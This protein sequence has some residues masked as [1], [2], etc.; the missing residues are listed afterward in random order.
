MTRL[1]TLSRLGLLFAA[2]ATAPAIAQTQATLVS[3][4]TP[5]QFELEGGRI[6]SGLAFDVPEGARQAR[7]SLRGSSPAH[8]IQLYVRQGTPFDL[9]APGVDLLQVQDQAHYRSTSAGSD[10][11]VVISDTS[12]VPLAAGRWF[13]AAVNLASSPSTLTLELQIW[14][15]LQTAPIELIFNDPGSTSDNCNQ[16][17]WSDGSARGPLRGNPGTTLGEQRRLAALEAARLLGDELKPRVPIRVRACWQDLGPASGTTFTLA[18]AGPRFWFVSAPYWQALAPA[19]QR[20]HTWYAAAAAA[21]QA[22][23]TACRL[24]RSLSCERFADVQINFNLNVDS[25]GSGFD[26]GFQHAVGA[27]SSFISVAMHEISHGLGFLGLINLNSS[28]GPVGSKIRLF[29]GSPLWDDIYGSFARW[30][31]QSNAGVEFLRLTDAERLQALTAGLN[32]RFSG[33]NAVELNPNAGFGPP[34]S[35]VSLHAPSVIA[36]GSTYSHVASALYGPQL[37]AANILASGPRQLGIARGILDDV[38]FSRQAKASPKFASAPSYQYFDPSR[39]GHGID[40]R[41]ISPAITGTDAEYFMGF[42]TFD[43]QGDPEWYIASG[44]LVDGVFIPKRNEFGDSLLRMR[45]EGPNQSVPDPSAGYSGQVRVNFNSAAL[46]PACHDGHP[47]RNLDRALA[48]MSFEINGELLEW[49]MQPVATPTS[50]ENDFSSIWYSLD[51]GGWGL[52]IQSFDNVPT[53]GLFSILYYADAQGLPRWAI[54]QE[55]NFQS[56]ATYPLRQVRGYCRTCPAPAELTFDEVGSI[57]FGLVR[58]GAGS[59]GNTVSFDVTYPG[60]QGG[61]FLRENVD[62]FPNSDPPPPPGG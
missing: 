53:D 25:G 43:A 26:Y 8:N 3:P 11:F 34:A 23:T 18:N 32:L 44:P 49:C 45:Y 40:F 14:N 46:H 42:Y 58:G 33:P 16:A 59:E 41:L 62:L 22:G 13:A 1:S 57:Q 4:G 47:G 52:A 39:N 61:R 17:P 10:E 24:E 30:T 27:P 38:G 9:R 50:V 60:P 51:D 56:G 31:P 28:N 37:M 29:N 7:V 12:G 55:A 5:L 35:L 54:A 20:Q 48:I 19:L 36:Q 6:T 2:L 15:E 21:Q